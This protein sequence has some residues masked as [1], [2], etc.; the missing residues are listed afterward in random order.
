MIMTHVAELKQRLSHYLRL[1]EQ[2]DEV[3][4]T[5][6]QRR[7]ARIVP[8]A[9]GDLPIRLPLRPASDLPPLGPIGK[10]LSSRGVAL[11]LEDRTRR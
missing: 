3:A 7:I 11:L 2:G 8:D 6:H 1:V 4:V 5:S 10:K 9:S